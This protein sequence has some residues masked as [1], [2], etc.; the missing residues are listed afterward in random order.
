MKIAVILLLAVT[1]TFSENLKQITIGVQDFRNY[2]PYSKY[3]GKVYSGFNRD[4]FE[5]FGREYGYQFTYKAL[6]YARL[7]TDFLNNEIDLIY[8][9]NPY[10]N[11]DKK[12]GHSIIYSDPVIYFTDGVIIHS[13]NRDKGVEQLKE[14]GTI[15]DFTPVEYIEKIENGS[16]RLIEKPDLESLLKLVLYKRIDGAY[17][18]VATSS[19]CLIDLPEEYREKL[20]FNDKLPYTESYRSL[21]TLKNKAV[22]DNFNEFLQK[23]SEEIDS[24]KSLHHVH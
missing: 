10:W 8:P 12:E 18:N 6:P 24:L 2:A 14:L 5:L 3:D 4:I 20:I 9:N 17:M 16:I 13:D 21:S 1:L 7:I 23:Y 22:I 15:I 19:C 11:R